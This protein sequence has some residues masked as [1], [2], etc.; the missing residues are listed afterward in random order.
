MTGPSTNSTA[1]SAHP[2]L[3]PK[4]VYDPYQAPEDIAPLFEA[5]NLILHE[6]PDPLWWNISDA[7]VVNMAFPRLAGHPHTGPPAHVPVPPRRPVHPAPPH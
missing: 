5:A 7:E 2:R 1:R 4:P 3:A 6:T